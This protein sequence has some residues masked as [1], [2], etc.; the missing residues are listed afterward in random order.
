MSFYFIGLLIRS[1]LNSEK[2]LLAVIRT[3]VFFF[4]FSCYCSE[5][6]TSAKRKKNTFSH[7]FSNFKCIYYM[8][9][10][11]KVCFRNCF[12]LRLMLILQRYTKKS[13]L[14]DNWWTIALSCTIIQLKSSSSIH[15]KQ[16]RS[17]SS[18]TTSIHLST[19][20]MAS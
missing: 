15:R 2:L 13:V 8:G 19:Q 20:Q 1:K 18:I 9:R 4:F 3:K 17:C 10:K 7:R 16:C 5:G 12:G 6:G 14:K 11:T